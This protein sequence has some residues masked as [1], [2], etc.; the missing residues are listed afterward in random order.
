MYRATLM[1]AAGVLIS[2]AGVV[3]MPGPAG[4]SGSLHLR[5]HTLRF[6]KAVANG[7][8]EGS[9]CT[10]AEVT[11]VNGTAGPETITDANADAPFGPTYG[12]ECAAEYL[13]V[14]PA[15]TSCTFQFAFQPLV[16]GVLSTGTGTIYFADG[17]IHTVLTV[18]LRGK[19][20]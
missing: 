4:A 16:P 9:G 17:S 14:V 1:V 15:H 20:T 8:C 2:I 12:G 13:S 5:P 6:A 3:A 7:P 18:N 19:S 10:F 11:I